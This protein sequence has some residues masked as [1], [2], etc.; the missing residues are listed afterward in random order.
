MTSFHLVE[1]EGGPALEHLNVEVEEG[2]DVLQ[3]SGAGGEKGSVSDV[4]ETSETEASFLHWPADDV[5]GDLRWGVKA[6]FPL[7]AGKNLGV[8]RRSGGQEQIWQAGTRGKVQEG[9]T[10]G[11]EKMEGILG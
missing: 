4:G 3:G 6:K 7:E 11:D 10:T 1:V 8:E 9:E 5:L 2:H